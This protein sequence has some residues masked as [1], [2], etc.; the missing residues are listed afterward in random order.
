MLFLP[1]M[2]E[3][4]LIVN[5]GVE[6]QITKS[7]T[8]TLS[9]KSMDLMPK[10]CLKIEFEQNQDEDETGWHLDEEIK[11]QIRTTP[12]IFKNG[13]KDYIK[14][15]K[16]TWWYQEELESDDY[17][18]HP[19]TYT[20]SQLEYDLDITTVSGNVIEFMFLNDG[21]NH[22][23]EVN[24]TTYSSH[25]LKKCFDLG[26]GQFQNCFENRMFD[27]FFETFMENIADEVESPDIV[28]QIH[29]GISN[30][31]QQH[32]TNQLHSKGDNII[33]DILNRIAPS[34][35]S[36]YDLITQNCYNFNT[37]YWT[38]QEFIKLDVKDV[39]N[40]YEE[41]YK[42]IIHDTPILYNNQGK[43]YIN[44]LQ[45]FW[46]HVSNDDFAIY[47]EEKDITT[48][49]VFDLTYVVIIT[50]KR[51][52]TI[53]YRL[54]AENVS[55]FMM[56]TPYFHGEEKNGLLTTEIPDEYSSKMKEAI[57]ERDFPKFFHYLLSLIKNGNYHFSKED[58]DGLF[59]NFHDEDYE[60][61]N[62][63]NPNQITN[64]DIS[65][66][67]QNAHPAMFKDPIVQQLFMEAA[68]EEEGKSFFTWN[69][70]KKMDYLPV[71][72]AGTKIQSFDELEQFFGIT[73][74]P[75]ETF[76]G[77][78]KL[79][80]IK[81][82]RNLK[83]IGVQ[84][85]HDCQKLQT[86]EIP[87]GVEMISKGA[88]RHCISL[89]NVT[90][91]KSI[92]TI[93]VDVFINCDNLKTVNFPEKFI[94]PN[95]IHLYMFGK[96]QSGGI[97][98]A[99]S[100]YEKGIVYFGNYAIFSTTYE[101]ILKETTNYIHPNF[102]ANYGHSHIEK[103]Y[104]PEHLSIP[105]R[106]FGVNSHRLNSYSWESPEI[107]DSNFDR[108]EEIT[109]HENN[110]YYTIING[111]LYS[112]DGKIL[113]LN[114]QHNK[115]TDKDFSDN[116]ETIKE[117]SLVG[118]EFDNI[119][120]P[121][122]VK[123][124]NLNCTTINGDITLPSTLET[125]N[126]RK[127]SIKSIDLS[128]CSK[129]NEEC[130]FTDCKNIEHITIPD[131]W[132]KLPD[133]FAQNCEKLQEITIP[134]NISIIGQYAFDGCK[135]LNSV[136][137]EGDI[138]T[139]KWQSFASCGDIAKFQHKNIKELESSVFQ[140]TNIKNFRFQTLKDLEDFLASIHNETIKSYDGFYVK[141]FVTP[142]C[143]VTFLGNKSYNEHGISY[144]SL[145]VHT[146]FVSEGIEEIY[147]GIGFKNIKMLI[148][149][150]TL[151]FI[152]DDALSNPIDSNAVVIIKNTKKLIDMRPGA[153][154][155]YRDNIVFYVPQKK[156]KN[157]ST[158]QKYQKAGLKHV[159]AYD[160]EDEWIQKFYQT[161]YN[162]TIGAENYTL[163]LSYR[164][165]WIPDNYDG[166]RGIT[167]DAQHWDYRRDGEKKQ[168]WLKWKDVDYEL[169]M[170]ESCKF[171]FNHTL[172]EQSGN[173]TANTSIDKSK[174][175]SD[176]L[177]NFVTKCKIEYKDEHLFLG[178]QNSPSYNHMFLAELNK[179][180][181]NPESFLKCVE[182][183]FPNILQYNV[184]QRRLSNFKF[185]IN[186]YNENEYL[187][188]IS[189]LDNY[190][191]SEIHRLLSI[192]FDKNGE[193]CEDKMT[194]LQEEINRRRK[195]FYVLKEKMK[196]DII[197][198]FGSLPES[199]NFNFDKKLFE[200]PTSQTSNTKINDVK[201]KSTNLSPEMWA[202]LIYQLFD[203][204][205]DLV[206][207]GL[208][209]LPSLY[210]NK[211]LTLK[212]YGNTVRPLYISKRFSYRANRNKY[213][214]G[215]RE[216][217]E[218]EN[219]PMEYLDGNET[220][221]K[222]IKSINR[223]FTGHFIEV[224]IDDILKPKYNKEIPDS[225]YLQILLN[226]L[227]YAIDK[228]KIERQKYLEERNEINESVHKLSNEKSIEQMKNK[229]V[230]LFGKI[231]NLI[232][233]NLEFY[234]DDVDHDGSFLAVWNAIAPS[235]VH[236]EDAIYFPDDSE[237][238][239]CDL[240]YYSKDDEF[241]VCAYSYEDKDAYNPSYLSI[242]MDQQP[243]KEMN[244]EYMF[245]NHH[246]IFLK[247]W[248]RIKNKMHI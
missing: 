11:N 105:E 177:G 115:F 127:S 70:I 242:N 22:I 34:R 66:M 190:D 146:L 154:N 208:I 151:K 44:S 209:T 93:S 133:H 102:N 5:E 76:K 230:D 73:A 217:W 150:S 77:C 204:N 227:I 176:I 203:E 234:A 134:E 171:D 148:L 237:L 121:E 221:P 236:K 80:S 170:S 41:E 135:T 173:Q 111:A 192:V 141:N 65:Q 147:K 139:M 181:K 201:R 233:D 74:L 13:F 20:E 28:L 2:S 163:K 19:E 180:P 202:K 120:I 64:V 228:E 96:S 218:K 220:F 68:A 83:T 247:V 10:P 42:D 196:N 244:L 205:F 108:L 95:R 33:K 55:R 58:I 32:N 40:L 113:I 61:L 200:S 39:W 31:L 167:Y 179:T 51:G 54:D 38:G 6:N 67:E 140:Y 62:E 60:D 56:S 53:S 239:F 223:K 24:C 43:D 1:E 128:K 229:S 172:N 144:D 232:K 131:H 199:T 59:F 222:T 9:N 193:R 125:L 57:D 194:G 112:K 110:P 224:L 195:H 86:I 81:L 78:T 213:Q 48:C 30:Q 231:H 118:T 184:F 155:S 90:I 166:F 85:F 117:Y 240:F 25:T 186:N 23:Q 82:P 16:E 84:C 175:K 169:D 129:L 69:E 45:E 178:S 214:I 149:P 191:N 8:Q 47:D 206:Q 183:Y 106:F 94:D 101:T 241:R 124:A 157:Y 122:G 3:N 123:Y 174:S 158:S 17:L 156:F 211:D 79:Q 216:T 89:D 18:N 212:M 160:N 145:S 98:Y 104:I 207:K 235:D 72:L 130:K 14:S 126:M 103:L 210:Q 226:A 162:G 198:I 248:E 37:S 92:I 46:T 185:Q 137:I 182:N 238:V 138:E 168:T 187:I 164:H 49:D 52:V 91:P 26:F 152:N 153:F 243:N 215:F 107:H 29:E 143:D 225:S 87:E 7:N 15:W 75:Q 88:F 97:E 63:S 136:I 4:F 245:K 116:L 100:C 35:K 246:D 50:T 188:E 119:V 132:P 114:P 189:M 165:F 21:L 109:V 99:R 71:E 36:G 12:I 161:E 142:D 27:D 159:E 197:K 219:F